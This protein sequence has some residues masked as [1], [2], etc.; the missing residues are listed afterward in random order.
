MHSSEQFQVCSTIA[1]TAS[2]R[3]SSDSEGRKSAREIKTEIL[4]TSL[5][6]STRNETRVPKFTITRIDVVLD[7]PTRFFCNRDGKVTDL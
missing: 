5:R 4:C 2:S 7:W 3:G 6:E 1:T